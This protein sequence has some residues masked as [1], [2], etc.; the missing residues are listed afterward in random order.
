MWVRFVARAL[1]KN[2]DGD[3][4]H[5]EAVI[6][7]WRGGD[8]CP[9][10]VQLTRGFLPMTGGGGA[11]PIV[12]R[13]DGWRSRVTIGSLSLSL[14]LP[15]SASLSLSLS[16]SLSFAPARVLSLSLW[17]DETARSCCSMLL[18]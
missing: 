10:E 9:E 7:L 14:S 1:S 6:E 17:Y 18:L 13:N 8:I 5:P 2:L 11:S 16:L 4:S 3:L 15:L 12:G